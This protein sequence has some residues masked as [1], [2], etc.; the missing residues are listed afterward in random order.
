MIVKVDPEGVA[1]G[2]F[3]A[4]LPHS[5]LGEGYQVEGS[6]RKPVPT[7]RQVLWIPKGA[8]DGY[9]PSY[10]ALD[11]GRSAAV[12]GRRARSH[13]HPVSRLEAPVRHRVPSLYLVRTS[14]TFFSIS[15]AE[16]IP[17]SIM[18]CSRPWAQRS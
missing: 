10:L 1:A 18:S 12:P 14:P 2:P 15:S 11:V 6:L 16:T 13:V 8:V 17:F 4:A 9:H 7:V 5:P 3:V